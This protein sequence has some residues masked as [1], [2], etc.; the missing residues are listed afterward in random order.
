[1]SGNFDNPGG[2]APIHFRDTATSI[3]SPSANV[4]TLTGPTVDVAGTFSLNSANVT[5]TAPELNLLDASATTPAVNAF[6][7]VPRI[8]KATY[9]FSVLGGSAETKTLPS[10]TLPDNAIIVGGWIDTEDNLGSSG[11]ASASFGATLGGST[12][13]FLGATGFNQFASEAGGPMI[14]VSQATSP[15]T[16]LKLGAATTLTMTISTAALTSGIVHLYVQYVMGS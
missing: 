13:L 3:H 15:A 7:A 8:A 9:D 6:A 5:S 16:Y 11:A 2:L 12:T 14:P 4:L 10:V 1:M